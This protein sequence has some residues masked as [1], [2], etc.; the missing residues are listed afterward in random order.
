VTEGEWKRSGKKPHPS[1]GQPKANG[2]HN[3]QIDANGEARIV[4]IG[5]VVPADGFVSSQKGSLQNKQG[6][7]SRL[8]RFHMVI[9]AVGTHAR[10]P[11]PKTSAHRPPATAGPSN[12]FA[13]NFKK[14]ASPRVRVP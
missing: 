10:E 8:D 12:W 13:W 5:F 1:A 9:S 7:E 14:N 11:F 6:N 3:N 4:R 2:P